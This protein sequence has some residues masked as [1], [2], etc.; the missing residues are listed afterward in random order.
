MNKEY[1]RDLVDAECNRQSIV[2]CALFFGTD[3]VRILDR[4]NFSADIYSMIDAVVTY[5][6]SKINIELIIKHVK[7]EERPELPEEALREVVVIALAHRDS[8]EPANVQVYI[9]KE[10]VEFLPLGGL[11]AGKTE[12]D[13]G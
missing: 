2:A 3:K 10:R 13:L 4:Q 7:R 8:R 5:I 6:L 9:F 11:P 12:A 1:L